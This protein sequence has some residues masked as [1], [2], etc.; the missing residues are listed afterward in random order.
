MAQEDADRAGVPAAALLAVALI[1]L[2]AGAAG[3]SC[4]GGNR[5]DHRNAECLSA[6]WKNRGP[7]R[8]SP[9][10]VR[11]MC[12]EYGRVVAKVDLKSARDRTLHLYD[13]LPREGDT[14]HRIRSISCCSDT[15][16]LCN[17][18][19]V[20]T[21]AGCLARYDRL[22]PATRTCR[23]EFASAAISGDAYNCTITAHC[24]ISVPPPE[25]Y[26]YMPTRITV[27]WLDL[28]DLHN[29]RGYLTRGPC[30]GAR[31]AALPD[32]PDDELRRE[33][34]AGFGRALASSL[35]EG[36]GDRLAGGA[37]E[38][39][40]AM[41]GR[42]IA[43]ITAPRSFGEAGARQPA[44]QTVSGQALLPGS[45]FLFAGVTDRAGGRWSIWG[46]AAPMPFAGTGRAGEQSFLG[47]TGIDYG[48][49]R[50]LAGLALSHGLAK[51]G[52][53]PDG[54]HGTEASLSGIHP[55]ARL[56]LSD[57]IALWG[58]LGH[59]TGE[60]TAAESAGRRTRTT[61]SMAATGAEGV[62]LDGE[63]TEGF[64]LSARSDAYIAR[65]SSGR[66]GLPAV[67]AVVSGLRLVLDGARRF[68]L[69]RDSSL[70]SSLKTGLRR[71][72]GDGAAEMGV[73]LE[74]AMDYE[75]AG[76]DVALRL[77]NRAGE[78]WGASLSAGH[79]AGTQG[80]LSFSPY[81]HVVGGGPAGTEHRFGL[82]LQMPLGPG[83]SDAGTIPPASGRRR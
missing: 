70:T 23:N 56:S 54:S 68:D 60:M 17:R 83:T 27:P 25:L 26:P 10:Y 48:R 53:A 74:A 2:P 51:G 31:A 13:G 20:V 82:R 30:G 46:Q 64:L 5:V 76:L 52:L 58:T 41:A 79:D 32:G 62:L 45:A 44:P 3:A 69:G 72:G 55:Y 1:L 6:W 50:L 34:L 80:R 78:G 73:G 4:S 65:I 36:L 29:C 28:G 8:T 63:E 18:S 57:R 9:Y 24:W 47:L 61:M 42:P 15:G 14:R 12:A 16:A 19:E 75:A 11:N 33:R 71:E 81:W 59:A 49:G 7:F 77:W 22:S 40:A 37:G 21:D 35:A 38:P 43:P 66:R 39:H 67:E